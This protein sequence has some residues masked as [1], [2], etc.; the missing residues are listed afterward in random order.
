MTKIIAAILTCKNWNTIPLTEECPISIWNL[1]TD[2]RHQSSIMVSSFISVLLSWNV[3][4]Y[5]YIYIYT[6]IILYIYIY[7]IIYIHII[8]YIYIYIIYIYIYMSIYIYIY[9][10]IRAISIIFWDD[11][12]VFYRL[13]D[14]Y[15]TLL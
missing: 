10:Y 8:I 7:N 6:H 9:T 3:A 5:V 2:R 4:V 15:N 11:K 14:C 13:L 12:H 1:H